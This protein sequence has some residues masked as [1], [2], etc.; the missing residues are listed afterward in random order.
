MLVIPYVS[1]VYS[2]SWTQCFSMGPEFPSFSAP[3]RLEIEAVVN[4]IIL[5]LK[6]SYQLELNCL[7]SKRLSTFNMNA[8]EL[9]PSL[10]A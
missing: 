1:T 10:H 2:E 3:R 8:A 7:L 4:K 9:L 6:L 5:N